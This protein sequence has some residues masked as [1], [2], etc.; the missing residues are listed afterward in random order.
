MI[1]IVK[2]AVSAGVLVVVF[3]LQ[4]VLQKAIDRYIERNNMSQR[5]NLAMHKTKTILL[6]V[7]CIIAIGIV[8]GFSL[9]N[10]WVSVAGFLGLVAIGFFAV[11]SILS[12][13]FAGIVIFFNQT[14]RLHDTIEI[15]PEGIKGSIHDINAFFIT[16]QDEEG[17]AISIPNNMIFQKI[18]KKMK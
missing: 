14:F 7:V 3:I 13:V 18:V 11:W 15:V 17:N 8:W 9:E 12:N 6:Y 1:P 2:I 10:V 5:R 16:L 4:R